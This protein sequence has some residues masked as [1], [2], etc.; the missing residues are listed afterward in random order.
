MDHRKATATV[1]QLWLATS[2]LPVHEPRY[3]RGV[4]VIAPTPFHDD[5]AS[6]TR[7]STA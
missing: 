2:P 6:T 7:R 3:C 5:A 4:Y 1:V